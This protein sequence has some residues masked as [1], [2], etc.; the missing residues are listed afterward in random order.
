[1]EIE[2]RKKQKISASNVVRDQLK[3]EPR[4]GVIVFLVFWFFHT[5]EPNLLEMRYGIVTCFI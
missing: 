5:A 4:H 3:K 1:M 2:L